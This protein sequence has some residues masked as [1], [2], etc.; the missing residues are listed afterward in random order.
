MGQKTNIIWHQNR[1][2]FIAQ[3]SQVRRQRV[4]QIVDGFEGY[5]L[6]IVTTSGKNREIAIFPAALFEKMLGQC[7][8]AFARKTVN[9]NNTT[10]LF[11]IR[12]LQRRLQLFELRLPTDQVSRGFRFR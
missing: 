5:G 3:A 8:L 2:I 10:L 7:G 11:R 6:A 4:D 12:M 9:K 1:S